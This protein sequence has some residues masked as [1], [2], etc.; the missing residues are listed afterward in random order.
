[1]DFI[2]HAVLDGVETGLPYTLAFLGI[3]LTFRLQR[4]FDLT[5]QGTF[6]LGAAVMASWTAAGHDVWIGLLLAITAG[7]I[8]GS[9]TYAVMRLLDLS[10]LLASIIV[11]VGLYSVNLLIMGMPNKS[12]YDAENIVTQWGQVFPGQS[13][14]WASIEIIGLI[15]LAICALVALF[16]RSEYGLAMRASG[17]NPAMMRANG[18]SPSVLLYLAV[19]AGNACCALSGALV[20]QQQQ[21][22]DIQMGNGTIVFGI[23]AILIGE[24][25]VFAHGSSV[26][27]VLAVLV[28]TLLYRIILAAT[29]RAGLP[30]LYFQ[31]ATSAL[32]IVLLFGRNAR[33]SLRSLRRE[34][35][36][37]RR[38]RPRPAPLGGNKTPAAGDL[39]ASELFASDRT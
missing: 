24:V 37:R 12:L 7:A 10:L 30:P 39:P 33:S 2:Q 32:V 13:D 18:A 36:G 8:A 31:G 14:T 19:M 1:M 17:I 16:L 5:V 21:F 38:I 34:L 28:G 20:A 23:T 25:V 6:P 27:G 22:A 29:F 11:G 3:W 4:E 26:R 35:I 15:T 9:V